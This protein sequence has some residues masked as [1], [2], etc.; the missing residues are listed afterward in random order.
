MDSFFTLLQCFGPLSLLATLLLLALLSRRL[1]AALP[2]RKRYYWLLIAAG[3][4][5]AAALAPVIGLAGSDSA[6]LAYTIGTAL[7]LTIAAPVAWGYWGW[8]LGERQRS[9]ASGK[10]RDMR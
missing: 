8:L 7:A 2:S 6:M 3:I 10:H 9:A 4:G 5:G 1:S